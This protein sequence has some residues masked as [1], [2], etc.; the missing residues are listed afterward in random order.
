MTA[1]YLWLFGSA[2]A[3]FGFFICA[4]LT[5]AKEADENGK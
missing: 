5:L 4:A 1:I 3:V 2:C